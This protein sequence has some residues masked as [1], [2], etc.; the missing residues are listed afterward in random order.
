MSDHFIKTGKTIY[1]LFVDAVGCSVL[2]TFH[3]YGIFLYDT[4]GT[5]VLSMLVQTKQWYMT[6]VKC[7]QRDDIDLSHEIHV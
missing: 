1:R 4:F 3:L 6:R 2:A 5:I 7:G